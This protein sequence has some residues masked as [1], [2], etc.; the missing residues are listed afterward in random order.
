M[1][2]EL[3]KLKNIDIF[4]VVAVSKATT[5]AAPNVILNRIKFAFIG[6]ARDNGVEMVADIIMEIIT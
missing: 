3:V 2:L 5:A 6:I 4:T 1:M